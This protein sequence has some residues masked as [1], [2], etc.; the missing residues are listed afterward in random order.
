[1]REATFCV[2]RIVACA[3]LLASS[4]A[5]AA[6]E[7]PRVFRVGFITSQSPST[8]PNGVTAFRD[9]LR[10]LGYI[11]GENLVIEARWSGNRYDRLPAL[12]DEVIARKVDILVVAATPA[13]LAAMNATK[14]IPIVGFGLADPVRSG[15]ATNVAHP[16]KNLT[17]FSMGWTEGAAGKWLELL[18]DTVPRLSAVAVLANPDNTLVRELVKEIK[19]IAPSRGLKI[20]VFDVREPAALDRALAKAGREAQGMVVLPD[21]IMAAHRG[22]IANLAAKAR[23]PAV[24]Y[25]RDFVEAGGL[26]SYGPELSIMSRRAADYVDK[27]LKGAKP[28]DL[29]IEQPMEYVL[30]VNLSAAEGLKLKIPEAVMMR[31]SEVVR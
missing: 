1:M 26:M 25:L 11:Q 13:A 3:L 16:D 18:Q 19:A 24:Y 31:A 17:G 15:L 4:V 28:S 27:I 5:P 7:S 30:A 29:P 12:V 10:E 21:P 9:R 6:D 22:R 14:S 8:A 2:W 20:R 23:L